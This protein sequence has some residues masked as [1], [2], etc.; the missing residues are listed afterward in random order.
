MWIMI[1]RKCAPVKVPLRAGE[2]ALQADSGFV[3]TLR[4]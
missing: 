4:A 3:K 2:A 1:R